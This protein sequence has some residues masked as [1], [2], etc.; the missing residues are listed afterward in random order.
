MFIYATLIMQ[1]A[2]Y[3]QNKQEAIFS[4]KNEKIYIP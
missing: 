1:I 3:K 2:A 4:V